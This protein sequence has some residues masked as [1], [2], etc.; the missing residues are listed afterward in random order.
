ME[1][2]NPDQPIA[3]L[4]KGATL[5]MEMVVKSGKGYVPAERN[6]TN[7]QPIGVIAFDAAFSPIEKVNHV[8]TNARVGSLQIMIS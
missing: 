1:I 4:N 8:V 2:L 5:D 7:D 3:T 6:T